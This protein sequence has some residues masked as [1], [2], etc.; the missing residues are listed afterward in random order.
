MANF[1]EQGSAIA[2]VV[3]EQP[4]APE[5]PAAEVQFWE[6]GSIVATPSVGDP[7]F[8][9]IAEQVKTNLAAVPNI[10]ELSALEALDAGWGMSVTGLMTRGELPKN[11][12][13]PDDPMLN[14]MLFMVGQTVGDFP[15]TLAGAYYGQE[16]GTE[17][18]GAPGAM[19]G[20]G[21]GGFA[22]PEMIRKSYMEALTKGQIKSLDDYAARVANIGLTTIKSAAVGAASTGLGLSAGVATKAAGPAISTTVATATEIAAMTTLAKTIEGELPVMRD[23]TDVAIILGGVKSAQAVSNKLRQIYVATN[24]KPAE[25]LSMAGED[26]LLRQELMSQSTDLPTSLSMFADQTKPK[27]KVDIVTEEVTQTMPMLGEKPSGKTVSVAPFRTEAPIEMGPPVAPKLDES[28][29]TILN[30]IAPE[31]KPIISWADRKA[32]AI[33]NYIDQYHPVAQITAILQGERKLTAIEDPYILMRLNAG[34]YGRA[35]QVLKFGTYD[36]NTLKTNGKSFQSA[37]DPIKDDFDSFK[38]YAIAQRVDELSVR[39]IDSGVPLLDAKNVIEKQKGNKKFETAFSDVVDYQNKMT[40]Y[41]KDS[42]VLDEKSYNQMIEINKSYIPMHRFFEEGGKPQ[43]VRGLNV[44]NPIKKIK[45][46][47]LQI[48]DPIESIVKN[49]Y[50]YVDIAEKNRALQALVKLAQKSEYKDLIVKVKKPTTAINVEAPEIAKYLEEHGIDLKDM[51]SDQLTIFRKGWQTLGSD[52]FAVFFD[53]KREVYKTDPELIKSLKSMDAES[54]SVLL[55][56]LS[57]PAKALRAGVTLAPDFMAKNVF[58]DQF[59]AFIQGNGYVPI[60]HALRGIG[61]LFKKDQAYQDW[62]KSGGANSAMVS[63]DRDYIQNNL[64]K[65]NSE[66]KF[67]EA[68]YNVIKS[69]LEVLRLASELTENMTRLGQFKAMVKDGA[70]PAEIFAAG[71]A[72]RDVTVDFLRRGAQMRGLT[73]QTAFLNAKVQG[74]D[75]MYRQLIDKPLETVI[76]GMV[77]YTLPSLYIWWAAY[78]DET[79]TTLANGTV[80]TRGDIYRDLPAWQRNMFHIIMTGVD[81]DLTIYRLPKIFEYGLL[82]GSLPERALESFLE[83]NAEAL[84]EFGKSLTESLAIDV[85]P[86]WAAPIIEQMANKSFFKGS[87]IVSYNSEKL[88]PE[89]QY[90]EYTSETAK[91]IAKTLRYMPFMEQAPKGAS[92]QSPLVI[93]NYIRSFTGSLGPILINQLEAGLQKLNVIA[94]KNLPE[95]SIEQLPFVKAF[96]I[97][98]PSS[99]SKSI[100][101]FFTKFQAGEKVTASFKMLLE[102]KDPNAIKFFSKNA[103]QIANLNGL[104]KAMT[105]NN[106]TIT[107]IVANPDMTPS[108]KRN[109]I[110]KLYATRIVY[111]QRG[112]QILEALEMS[113]KNT[114]L[115]K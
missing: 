106:R 93:D 115:S 12:L 34:N 48:I 4:T 64:L 43:S 5:Q 83:G 51:P 25:I 82:F 70:S 113:A 79:K 49:T 47:E 108:D 7:D 28:V 54:S 27:T 114:G 18:G 107:L 91:I 77:G 86:T 99:S 44:K 8:S 78:S 96:L 90:N 52:E 31:S 45:G 111:A 15:A 60:Y 21:A 46:S 11:Q 61:S 68:T 69:P 37:I 100:E 17:L 19:I 66:T 89:F 73:Q 65:L 40:K 59:V 97:R 16:L 55:K 9:A 22:V 10:S 24:K 50:L 62:L 14:R 92:I 39:N 3:S 42:G 109:L 103:G 84:K 75:R 32:G 102:K 74:M 88:L 81:E 41:L 30:R 98:Y 87:P 76:K 6:K 112:L 26:P 95:K 57:A 20:G 94:P 29:T 110:D 71:L 80:T 58:R 85:T 38:A 67:I 56:I 35:D 72:S 1:W 36:F 105:L 104:E 101:T 13:S 53:G 33:T 23:F 2:P 63:I